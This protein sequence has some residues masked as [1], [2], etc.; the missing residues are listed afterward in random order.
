MVAVRAIE[1]R[2]GGS[3]VIEMRWRGRGRQTNA[4]A[5]VTRRRR[6]PSGRRPIRRRMVV[7]VTR[8]VAI[9]WW[10]WSLIAVSIRRRPMVEVRRPRSSSSS[11]IPSKRRPAEASSPRTRLTLHRFN[12]RPVERSRWCVESPEKHRLVEVVACGEVIVYAVVT[13]IRT[14]KINDNS[15]LRRYLPE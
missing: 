13:C 14:R 6:L 5:G 8:P 4:E 15:H 11:A 9:P 1:V 12:V 7:S 10:R 3:P 2:H